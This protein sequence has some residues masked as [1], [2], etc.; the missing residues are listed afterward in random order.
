MGAWITMQLFA[1][2]L[3]PQS[4]SPPSHNEPRG[5]PRQFQNT[6]VE[7]MFAGHFSAVSNLRQPQPSATPASQDEGSHAF[8]ASAATAANDP[9][10]RKLT[11]PQLPGVRIVC[12]T[13]WAPSSRRADEE[14]PPRSSRGGERGHPR[15]CVSRAAGDVHDAQQGPHARAR[16]HSQGARTSGP[17]GPQQVSARVAQHQNAMTP[18]PTR[19]RDPTASARSARRTWREGPKRATAVAREPVTRGQK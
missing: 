12:C 17:P 11:R 18:D 5:A 4:S 3:V 6:A 14:R 13:G 15:P 10:S 2:S 16:H 7:Y 19:E 8:Q 9:N 1:L